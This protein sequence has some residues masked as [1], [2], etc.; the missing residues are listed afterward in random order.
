MNSVAGTATQNHRIN[1]AALPF[2]SQ[3]TA[4]VATRAETLM[5]G[6]ITTSANEIIEAA[7]SA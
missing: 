5:I 6:W 1:D 3:S 2:L 4:D 7:V